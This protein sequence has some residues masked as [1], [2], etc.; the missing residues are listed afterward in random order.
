V[1]WWSRDTKFQSS[2]V[3]K[4]WRSTLCAT[5]GTWLIILFYIFKTFLREYILSSFTAKI[6]V[7]ST[8]WDRR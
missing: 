1:R 7:K 5:K 8:K 6:K 3:N 4:F 2:N